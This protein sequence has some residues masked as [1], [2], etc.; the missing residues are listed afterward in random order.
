MHAAIS[1][2]PERGNPAN[3]GSA[4]RAVIPSSAS[5]GRFAGCPHTTAGRRT[6]FVSSLLLRVSQCRRSSPRVV[7]D[8]SSYASFTFTPR[9]HARSRVSLCHLESGGC[10]GAA[11][12]ARAWRDR[13]RRAHM[14]TV[15]C[16]QTHP[17]RSRRPCG[18]GLSPHT[19][20]ITGARTHLI[21]ACWSVCQR[22][23]TQSDS[24]FSAW[25]PV[26]QTRDMSRCYSGMGGAR[27]HAEKRAGS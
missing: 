20:P 16:A 25:S 24:F 1:V 27:L 3:V 14:E 4:A 18:V 17:E 26:T 13:N 12:A 6:V 22:S 21:A 7:P 5:A 8:P 23:S 15:L 11:G 19:K 9:D 10:T 2:R